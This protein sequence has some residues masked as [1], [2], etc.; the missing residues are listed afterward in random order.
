MQ[1]N[2]PVWIF[3]VDEVVINYEDRLVN[4]IVT[5]FIRVT[6]DIIERMTPMATNYT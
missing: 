6:L 5:T 2:N 1:N 4:E 3:V